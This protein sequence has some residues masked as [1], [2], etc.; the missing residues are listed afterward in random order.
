MD[1]NF[2]ENWRKCRQWILFFLLKKDL[3]FTS[4]EITKK[5]SSDLTVGG[6]SFF[7]FPCFLK[8]VL[9]KKKMLFSERV[10]YFINGFNSFIPIISKIN[11]F[12]PVFM[13]FSHW[14]KE[15]FF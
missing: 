8:K 10:F 4:N 9:V 5:I 7:L 15:I 14:L 3:S 6:D 11:M 12:V 2:W 13:I 1:G